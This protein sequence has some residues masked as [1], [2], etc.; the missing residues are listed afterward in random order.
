MG[1][2]RCCF[3]SR[4]KPVETGI[5]GAIL[6]H[7]AISRLKPALAIRLESLA[8]LNY[9]HIGSGGLQSTRDFNPPAISARRQ[10]KNRQNRD[11]HAAP[12]A[13]VH[14]VFPDDQSRDGASGD[15]HHIYD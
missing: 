11:K 12:F 6:I 1:K 3:R 2:N 7:L 5:D 10:Q 4:Q 14:F 9:H 8:L 13:V 15:Y